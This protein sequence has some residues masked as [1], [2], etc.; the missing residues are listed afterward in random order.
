MIPEWMQ[1]VYLE[2]LLGCLWSEESDDLIK[3]HGTNDRFHFNIT[4]PKHMACLD[5]MRIIEEEW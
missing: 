4:L 1:F 3:I 5:H 2:L